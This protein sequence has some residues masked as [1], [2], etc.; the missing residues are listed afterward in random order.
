MI[1]AGVWADKKLLHEFELL[2]VKDS[3]LLSDKHCHEL[4]IQI[5]TLCKG[6][7]QE[8]EIPPER[9]NELYEQFKAENKNLNHL[10]AWGHARAIESLL[11]RLSCGYAVADQ[12]GDEHYITSRLMQRGKSLKLI[13][14][15]KGERYIAVAAASIL[16]RD[17]FVRRLEQ[18]GHELGFVLPK[19]A[20]DAV[21]STAKNVVNRSG[22]AG[23]RKVAKIHFKT[24]S[25]VL[26]ERV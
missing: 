1:I 3:K 2:G 12:F 25:L 18:I 22:I 16:A 19:G 20:S 4:A 26:N 14:L 5:R 23:L 15:P 21:I 7:F 10:L 13:Q 17:C 6:N 8:V 24:T 9:Y 11:E